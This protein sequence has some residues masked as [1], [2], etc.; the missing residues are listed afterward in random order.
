MPETMKAMVLVQQRRPLELRQVPVP[1]PGPGEVLIKVEAC[2]VCRTD[3]HILDGELAHPKLPLIPGHEIIGRVAGLGPGA[4]TYPLGTRVGVPW[5][6]RSCGMCRYCRKG[7]ENLCLKAKFT[8]Y[9]LDGGYAEYCTAAEDYIYP[10]PKG[11]EAVSA[12]PLLCAG[13]IGYRSYAMASEA[14]RLGLYGFGAAAHIIIQ[15]AL[16]DGKQVFAFT[17]DGDTEKQRFAMKLGAKWAGGSSQLP[18]EPLDA[19]IIFAP[20]GPLVPQA[21]KALDRGGT[22]VCAGIYMSD[23][24]SFSYEDLWWEKKILSVA[25]LTRQDGHGFM[26]AASRISIKTETIPYPLED[27]N[28]AL[29]DLR[30]GRI[31]GAAVLIP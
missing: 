8:G 21:L 14:E 11:Y 25:N 12:A 10:V 30:S 9:H 31:K 17:R 28:R 23:I 13:L 24:P 5:L 19:A 18:P 16:H 26:E 29:E 20:A 27:A 22:L 2:G 15:V 6:A 1:E 7:L 4:G 3:L